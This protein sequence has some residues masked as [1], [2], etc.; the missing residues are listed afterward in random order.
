MTKVFSLKQLIRY[1][2]SEGIEQCVLVPKFFDSVQTTDDI[3]QVLSYKDK[4]EMFTTDG[5]SIDNILLNKLPS[6][7]RV[8]IPLKNGKKNYKAWEAKLYTLQNF[9]FNKVELEFDKEIHDDTY[10]SAGIIDYKTIKYYNYIPKKPFVIQTKERNYVLG[11]A[12]GIR[13][14]YNIN[15]N[16]IYAKPLIEKMHFN[17]LIKRDKK[18]LLIKDSFKKV[19]PKNFR[20]YEL[21]TRNIYKKLTK[22]YCD[23]QIKIEEEKVSKMRQIPDFF[24]D[25]P[26]SPYQKLCKICVSEIPEKVTDWLIEK[27]DKAFGFSFKHLE[28]LL[29]FI[30]ARRDA[31]DYKPLAV[32]DNQGLINLIDKI[33]QDAPNE[34]LDDTHFGNNIYF[35]DTVYSVFDD[36]DDTQRLPEDFL[37]NRCDEEY[38]DEDEDD[39][40]YEDE[41]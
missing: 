17:W 22:D 41:D 1:Y 34:P 12:L 5:M 11:N 26:L 21:I 13:D 7:C 38:E 6:K 9:A 40:E 3:I 8:S 14:T 15:G 16:T 33:Y 23:N 32:F 18:Y 25:Y 2:L 24:D 20:K 35:E 29:D 28:H 36:S 37:D 31:N 10:Y 27:I 4:I 39:E 30:D 19:F